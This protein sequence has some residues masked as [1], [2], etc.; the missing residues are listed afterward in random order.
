[1][2]HLVN[3]TVTASLT[4]NGEC[5]GGHPQILKLIKTFKGLICTQVELLLLLVLVVVCNIIII[6][7]ICCFYLG[8]VLYF[9]FNNY[10]YYWIYLQIKEDLLH[11]KFVLSGK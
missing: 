11:L 6:N 7:I 3:F 4:E 2:S 8:Y 5:L 1:M 9:L 10:Y